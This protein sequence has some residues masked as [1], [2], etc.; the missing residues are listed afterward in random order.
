MI[1]AL[2]AASLLVIGAPL[3][4][5]SPNLQ[6]TIT[7]LPK[8]SERAEDMN[9]SSSSVDNIWADFWRAIFFPSKYKIKFAKFTFMD[10]SAA[11]DPRYRKQKIEYD[12]CKKKCELGD[13]PSEFQPILGAVCHTACGM[14]AEQTHPIRA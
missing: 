5:E 2:L 9:D 14:V 6:P 13:Y 12:E 1:L 11:M 8:P 10:E 4:G 3:R 7:A